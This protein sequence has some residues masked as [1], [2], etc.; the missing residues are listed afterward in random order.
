MK[1]EEKCNL[2]IFSYGLSEKYQNATFK[3][4]LSPSDPLF[5][6]VPQRAI[7]VDQSQQ[8]WNPRHA[9]SI[10]KVLVVDSTVYCRL[11][12]VLSYCLLYKALLVYTQTI[13]RV[14]LHIVVGWPRSTVQIFSRIIEIRD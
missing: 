7:N 6:M 11:T 1:S 2:Y 14:C 10:A 12:S 9:R 13:R 3:R 5:M 8:P 4:C